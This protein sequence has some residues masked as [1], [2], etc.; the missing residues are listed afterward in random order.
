MFCSEVA[1]QMPNMMLTERGKNKRAA[2]MGK[3]GSD[4]GKDD[5]TETG[6][7]L[8]KPRFEDTKSPGG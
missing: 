4:D 3:G 2:W 8:K 5:E 7:P 1:T 6:P